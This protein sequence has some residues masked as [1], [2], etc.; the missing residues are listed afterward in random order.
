MELIAMIF[1]FFNAQMWWVFKYYTEPFPILLTFLSPQNR[2]AIE[3]DK[4]LIL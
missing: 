1:S 2:V 4:K 3:K